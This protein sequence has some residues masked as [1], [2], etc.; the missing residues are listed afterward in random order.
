MRKIFLFILT[1][2]SAMTFAIDWSS[3]EWLKNGSGDDKN[4]NKY[5]ISAA[6]GQNVVDIQKPEWA[7]EAGIYSYFLAEVKSCT[8]LAEGKY[9]ILGA[10]VILYLSAFTQKETPVKIVS[11]GSEYECVVYYADGT[12]EE[13]KDPEPGES[14]SEGQGAV[15]KSQSEVDI[16]GTKIL[17]DWSITYNADQTLTFELSWAQAIEGVVPQ[18]SINK[19][20]ITIMPTS[21]QKAIYKT[22]ETFTKGDA[23]EAFFYIAYP[24]NA[25]RIDIAGYKVGDSNQSSG[26]DT[27]GEGS[28]DTPGEQ[29]G[30]NPGDQPGDQP[31]DTPGDQ[32]GDQPGEGPGEQPGD[33]GL[34]G[35]Q[36]T[37]YSVQKTFENG[38]LVIIKNGIRYGVNGTKINQ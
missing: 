9:K 12:G 27:P 8:G 18:I 10:G 2:V 29:P 7:A 30:D 24:N 38:Q 17:F 6:F 32:P 19:G 21:G 34:D 4:T 33:Q 36:S 35:V 13:S 20:D 23:L 1:L 31:G 25:A 5:K 28:G 37:E 14:G 16:A 22:K 3:V 11:G 15:Y 26:E